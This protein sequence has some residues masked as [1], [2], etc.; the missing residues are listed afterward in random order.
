MKPKLFLAM[1][2][3]GYG[4][5]AQT[6]ALEEFATGFNGLTEITHAGDDR[7]F[8]TEQEGI[9]KIVNADGTVNGTAFLDISSLLSTGGERGLLG[10]AFHPDFATNGYFFVDYTNVAG[11]TVIARY[12]RSTA[13]ANIA[14]P[15]TATILLTVEQPFEN[16]NGG[17]LRFG[18][19]GYL[20]IAMGDG[21]S[22]GDPNGNGQNKNVLLGKLLR[23]DVDGAAP[24]GIPADNPFVGIDGA[25]EIWAYGLRNPWKY[26]FNRL[27]GDLW[28]ADVGQDNIEEIN[29]SGGNPAGM[30]Y[31]WRCFEGSATFNNDGCSI[32]EM[33]TQPFAEYTH[34]ETQGCSITG[35]YIYT[36]TNYPNFLGKYIF[37][38]YCN[39]KIGWADAEGDLTYT[40]A[41][42]GNNFTVFGEDMDGELYIG[43]K[44]TGTIYRITDSELSTPTIKNTLFSLAPNPAQ[45]EV[46]ITLNNAT[47]NTAAT[48]YDLGGKLLLQQALTTDANRIDTSALQAG[49]YLLE[50]T[51]GN[52]RNVQK[53]VIN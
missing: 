50:V 53:L 39:N 48:V 44:T 30:N 18:P 41:F 43:G 42:N 34:S 35:G 33:Y 21:G 23:I 31:G 3:C 13:N 25:D 11:N 46:F 19:D 32:V 16:H 20:Y 1:L 40:D 5:L 8:V 6:I 38:D 47:G 17:C 37:A 7:F 22:G 52:G 45:N 10:L 9:I 26:S 12:T 4:A 29:K 28:I 15:S 24:Y 51:N 36:G 2:L 49:M 14:D 27:N